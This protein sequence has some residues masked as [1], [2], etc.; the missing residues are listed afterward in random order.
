M[1]KEEKRLW[2]EQSRMNKKF[3]ELFEEIIKEL[4]K[5][6]IKNL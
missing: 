5:L 3:I 4:R 6:K 2:E 1:E